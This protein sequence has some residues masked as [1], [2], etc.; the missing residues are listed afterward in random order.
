MRKYTSVLAAAGFAMLPLASQAATPTLGDVLKASGIT[1]SGYVDFG[2][3]V[4]NR[5]TD[6]NLPI[7]GAFTYGGIGGLQG[8]Q[9][10]SFRLNQV[11]LTVNTAISD[12]FSA[13]LD[14]L[15][16][17]DAQ[18]IVADGT[19]DIKF[20]Q[21]YIT[22]TNGNLT[23]LGGR[24]V[25]L[26]GS[27][28]I[29]SSQNS[30]ATRGLLFTFLQPT[31]HTGIRATYSINKMVSLTGGVVNSALSTGTTFIV[32]TLPGGASALTSDN[33]TQKTIEAQVA[34]NPFDGFSNALTFYRG[35]ETTDNQNT[36]ASPNDKAAPFLID[37]VSSLQVT[38][39]LS[40]GL[41][42]DYSKPMDAFFNSTFQGV[43][44]YGNFQVCN[45]LRLGGRG[46]YVTS[47][48]SLGSFVATDSRLD[49]FE[50]TL[51]A[52][53]AVA[54]NFNVMT[55]VRFD[56]VNGPTAIGT[57]PAFANGG[58]GFPDGGNA[59][60]SLTVKAIYRF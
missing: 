16:G 28:V 30:N 44:L 53:Y 55:D 19:G 42:Y 40:L 37:L 57:I 35:I 12:S 8:A 2:T 9:D 1:A 7:G 49:A 46:E 41:N 26:A 58:K 3:T 27:E 33:N 15:A 13:T 5:G 29:N 50:Y 23:V 31:T 38:K 17:M 18:A 59:L 4:N 34:V 39:A 51:T 22:Y 20:K 14:V 45:N 32:A 52:D 56:K 11:G 10:G 21:A 47:V 24:F 25:T 48:N 6:T 54:K 36:T 60:T 43:A